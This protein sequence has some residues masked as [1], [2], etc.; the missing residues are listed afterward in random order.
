VGND[1]ILTTKDL[2]ECHG[3]TSTVQL[4]GKSVTA[5]HY[6]MTQDFP[7]SASCMRS[8]PTKAPGEP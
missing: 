8:T 6:V 4:D 5:Y 7:Y 2:D 3:I 1:N